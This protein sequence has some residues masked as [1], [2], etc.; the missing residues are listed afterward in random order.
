MT[1]ISLSLSTVDLISEKF[2]TLR[3]KIHNLIVQSTSANHRGH[4]DPLFKTTS[5]ILVFSASV[6]YNDLDIQYGKSNHASRI[7]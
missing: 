7:T 2:C 4:N 3:V 6:Y 1:H 5:G